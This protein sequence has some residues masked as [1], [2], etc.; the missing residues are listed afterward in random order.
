LR[1][2]Q[3]PYQYL[4]HFQRSKIGL[5]RHGNCR[6]H[7]G[8][9]TRQRKFLKTEWSCKRHIL[10]RCLRKK[11]N[12]YFLPIPFLK[13]VL[14]A[15]ITS[16]ELVQHTIKDLTYSESRQNDLWFIWVATLAMILSKTGFKVSAASGDKLAVDSPFVNFIQT[17][18]TMLPEKYYRRKTPGSI[19]KAIQEARKRYAG[20]EILDLFT[21]L[22][23]F[24]HERDYKK[25]PLNIKDPKSKQRLERFFQSD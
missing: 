13:N 8:R 25:Q 3:T 11:E 22:I 17:I 14:D 4:L 6:A 2:P 5:P 1:G 21:L 18:Q 7:L 15:A 9:S 16:G 20:L 12:Q 24:V 19:A 23:S 10:A